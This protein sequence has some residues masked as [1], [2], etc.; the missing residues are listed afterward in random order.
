LFVGAA[1]KLRKT[2]ISF[3]MSVCLYV[4]MEQIGCLWKDLVKFDI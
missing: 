2:A 3:V 1:A 4:R